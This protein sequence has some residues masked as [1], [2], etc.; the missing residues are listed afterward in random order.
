MDLTIVV[1][2]VADAVATLDASGR[3]FKAFSAGAGPYGEPQLVRW[4]TEFLNGKAEYQNRARVKRS[5]DLLVEGLWA[6]EVKVA[7]PFGDNGKE[8]ENWSVNLLHPYAGNV[9][10]IGDAM[11]LVKHAGPERR[12][13]LVVGY[14]HSPPRILL[15]PLFRGFELIATRVAQVRIGRRVQATRSGLVHVVH[16]QV[17]VAA[18]EIFAGEPDPRGLGTAEEVAIEQ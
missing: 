5:P 12:A 3:P 14:E 17:T 11:K 2:H 1:R 18:W 15:E 9:S 10:A 16:Q 4:I 8:A 6:L 13:V 7:R